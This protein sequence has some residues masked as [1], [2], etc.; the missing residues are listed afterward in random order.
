MEDVIFMMVIAGVAALF[1][2]DRARHKSRKDPGE[3]GNVVFHKP[4]D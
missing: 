3:P 1:V 4:Q 2:L